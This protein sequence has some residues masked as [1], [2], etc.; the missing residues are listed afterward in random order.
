LVTGLQLEASAQ[1]P[2]TS[3]IV[4]LGSEEC[5]LL[6]VVSCAEAI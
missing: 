6:E 4:G 3:T 2:W 1:A 5:L